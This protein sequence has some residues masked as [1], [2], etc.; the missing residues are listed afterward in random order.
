MAGLSGAALGLSAAALRA[1]VDEL[2]GAAAAGRVTLAEAGSALRGAGGG[3]DHGSYAE[4]CASRLATLAAGAQ[5][6]LV[7]PATVFV[8]AG[9]PPARRAA[10]LALCATLRA[11]HA[12]PARAAE[13]CTLA[14]VLDA[15]LP[16][17]DAAERDAA[18]PPE[19]WPSFF[20]GSRGGAR[21]SNAA[22]LRAY[23]WLPGLCPAAPAAGPAAAEDGPA[24]GSSG[25]VAP[26]AA[27]AAGLRAAGTLSLL[28]PPW[29][30]EAAP[31]QA[32][33]FAQELLPAAPALSSPSCLAALAAARAEGVRVTLL[34]P[35]R[36]TL[37][38]ERAVLRGGYPSLLLSV[39][40]STDAADGLAGADAAAIAAAARAG[41]DAAARA[42]M[43]AALLDAVCLLLLPDD[44]PRSAL[45][46]HSG[47]GAATAAR[48]VAQHCAAVGRLGPAERLLRSALVSHRARGANA[49]AASDAA[50]TE[51][52]VSED[53]A[54]VLAAQGRLTEAQRVLTSALERSRARHGAKHALTRGLEAQLLQARQA[55]GELSMRHFARIAAGK[56]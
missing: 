35:P 36:G 31:G 54:A 33:A 45:R 42:V 40:I 3:C 32:G 25:D 49:P 9:A 55:S 7:A 12:S 4:R 14:D 43:A 21:D 15:V 20:R 56:I 51:L 27:W 24:H 26:P 11:P 48:H 10:P 28:L 6:A 34:L 8:A 16:R 1:A 47:A 46:A 18:A 44:A 19:A 29:A 39:T 23:V 17:L 30:D 41:G 22:P 53:L 38:L 2:G 52:G 50:D 37:W 13:G 5:V